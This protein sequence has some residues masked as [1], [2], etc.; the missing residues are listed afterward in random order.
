MRFYR[1]V[2]RSFDSSSHQADVLL[3]GSLSRLLLA[4]PV[5][6]HIDPQL[7]VEGATCGVL[8]F[9]EGA[10]GALICTLGDPPAA[11]LDLDSWGPTLTLSDLLRGWRDDYLGD[12][13]DARYTEDS[14]AS[15]AGALWDDAPGGWLRLATSTTIY[16]QYKLWLGT[17]T[18]TISNVGSTTAEY[19]ILLRAKLNDGSDVQ[20]MFGA[21]DSSTGNDF[22]LA[23]VATPYESTKWIIRSRV[24]GGTPTVEASDVAFDTDWH[25]LALRAWY[26]GS[27]RQADFWVDGEL[28]ASKTTDMTDATMTPNFFLQTRTSAAI[29][30]YVDFFAVIPRQAA[31]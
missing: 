5:A 20:F 6:Q 2:I 4:V 14:Y 21:Q 18:G 24:G 19:V 1:G 10:S 17:Q 13:L 29:T 25:D 22:V 23:G 15:G 30:A 11:G 8:F 31:P 7:L 3:V 28:V 27:G 12:A 16:S 9:E 26:N